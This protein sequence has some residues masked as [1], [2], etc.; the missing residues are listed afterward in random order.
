M[1][2]RLGPLGLTPT[3]SVTNFGIDSNVFNDS[4][5]RQQDFTFTATPKVQARMRS[6][7]LLLG[8]VLASGLV[9]Y[10]KFDDQRSIDY[11]AQGRADVDLGW[12]QPYALAERLDTRDRLSVELDLRAPRVSTVVEGG[13]RAVFSPAMG[14]RFDARRTTVTFEDGEIFDGVFLSETL[15][16]HTTVLEGGLELYLTPLTT[17]T[18]MVTG[19]QDRFESRPDRDSDSFRVMP[20]LRLEAPAIIQG[21]I[22]VGYRRFDGRSAELP[23]YNG[24]VFQG[25]LSHVIA[26]RTKVDVGLSRDVQYSFE[27][28][29]P[30]YVTTG[31]RLSLSH[32]L[33]DTIDL[34][35][36]ASRD[37]L[38]YHAQSTATAAPSRSDRVL[39][40]SAGFGYHV[41]PNVRVGLDLE[42][43]RR[44]SERDDRQYDRTRLLGS[45]SY[46]F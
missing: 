32:Q 35:A 37:R 38:D 43:T 29:E 6:G 7:R 30:Y 33:R 18:V 10:Q 22:G 27:V 39:L 8:G 21:S 20:T 34:R 14:F 1:P 4:V 26:D 5:D 11:S 15:N 42:Y 40:Y 16:S 2:I 17:M 36:L 23:D 41:R 25:S 3:L 31:V 19:Q 9:Y 12:F 46:G 44:Q 13:G 24:L 28:L 45:A